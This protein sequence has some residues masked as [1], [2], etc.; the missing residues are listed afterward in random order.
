M[1]NYEKGKIMAK[2]YTTLL[3]IILFSTTTVA[4]NNSISGTY[5]GSYLCNQGETNLRLNIQANN[6]DDIQATFNFGF[7]NNNSECS[8]AQGAFLM[9]GILID[10]T[11]RLEGTEWIPN[12]HPENWR[13]RTLSGE[14]NDNTFKGFVIG[15][16]NGQNTFKVKKVT[17]ITNMQ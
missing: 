3:L 5:I 2:K 7:E 12:K 8:H 4:Q 9:K 17:N 13:M 10:N 1:I 15:C 11:L 16:P 6:E 14:I